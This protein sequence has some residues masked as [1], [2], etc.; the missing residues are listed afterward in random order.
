MTFKKQ[1]CFGIFFKKIF[2]IFPY[3][4]KCK[5]EGNTVEKCLSG[6]TRTVQNQRAS[7]S[8]GNGSRQ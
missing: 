3:K 7:T 1:V 6:S 2:W 5:Q 8:K 4:F